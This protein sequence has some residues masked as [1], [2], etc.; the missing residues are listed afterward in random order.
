MES[1][2]NI[3]GRNEN[4]YM[5]LICGK[6]FKQIGEYY[7]GLLKLRLSGKALIVWDMIMRK[8]KRHKKKKGGKIRKSG[9][10]KN[11]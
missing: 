6:L 1:Q 3:T 9:K 8:G 7:D 11:E 4:V 5:Q 10:N 2:E